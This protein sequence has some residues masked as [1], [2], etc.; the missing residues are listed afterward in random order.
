MSVSK[1]APAI[2]RMSLCKPTACDAKAE[3]VA[4][5]RLRGGG[6][7]GPASFF[8]SCLFRLVFWLLPGLSSLSGGDETLITMLYSLVL[9]GLLGA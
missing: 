2:R 1:Y 9:E 4:M 6:S 5:K 3:R 8:L 7:L